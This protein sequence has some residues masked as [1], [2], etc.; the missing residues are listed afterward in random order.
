MDPTTLKQAFPVLKDDPSFVYLD[1]AASSLKP[2]Y[3]LKQLNDYYE[4]Y[5]V[6][7]HRGVYNLSY[8]ATEKY[9]EARR[10]VASFINASDNEVVFMRGAS[11]A[12]N[13]VALSY[14]YQHV[15]KGD[16]IIVSELEH[17]SSILPWQ[18]LAKN[19]GAKLVFVPLTKSGRITV[20]NVK[21]V[22]T[23]KTK[24]VALTYVSNVMGYI[25]PIKEIIDIAHQHGAVVSVDAAQAVP[26]F[27]ID[28][29]ALDCDFLSFSG[30]KMLAPTGIGVLYGKYQLLDACP[31]VEFGGDM[32]DLVE[33]YDATY[34]DPPLKFETG[35]PPIAG[36]I[37]LGAAIDF[38]NDIGLD[39]IH[40]HEQALVQYAIEEMDK[41][42][43]VT[44]YN[45]T[46][47]TG[48]IAFNIDRVHPHDAVT[49]FD[50]H[51]IAMRAGHHCAQLVTQFLGVIST[52][53]ISFYLYNTKEDVDTFIN[54][55]QEAVTFFSSV[56][57]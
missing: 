43:G 23:D 3:V 12:L 4:H 44:V 27:K 47:D 56:G 32:I 1:S 8:V 26:H 6:N 41:I 54:A 5:G 38:L 31:P 11:S 45:P 20:D 49:I 53:R 48:V 35:T 22:M 42:E 15:K 30:H 40:R 14:G 52:L 34:Q 46:S 17:H 10:K 7:V 37:G 51:N 36:A 57:F 33:K 2:H 21:S 9:N 16:E 18:Q 13:F 24:V 28:V 55:L 39:H 25:T 19:V 29:K 50:E